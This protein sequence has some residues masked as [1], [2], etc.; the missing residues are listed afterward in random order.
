MATGKGEHDILFDF[1][2]TVLVLKDYPV[3]QRH[4]P[5]GTVYPAADR[6]TGCD[7]GPWK[8]QSLSIPFPN[9]DRQ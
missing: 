3:C 6:P 9:I 2:S 8:Y 4:G 5:D 7:C 1:F